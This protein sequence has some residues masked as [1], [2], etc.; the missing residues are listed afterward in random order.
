[1]V[2]G[3]SLEQ[4][5]LLHVVISIVGILSGFVVAFGLLNGKRLEWWRGL[6]IMTTILTD[7]TGY[8]FPFK[9]LLPSHIVGGISLLVLIFAVLARYRK[10]LAGPWR[11]IYVITAMIA[12]YLNVFVLIVQGFRKVP[13]L[14][15]LAPTGTETPFKIVQLVV[16]IAFVILTEIGRA[17]V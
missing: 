3:M 1:M 16:L 12:L 15:A 4:F 14:T 10:K 11:R 9:E 13:A 6:C 17:H 8:L 7:L 2:L 5:T